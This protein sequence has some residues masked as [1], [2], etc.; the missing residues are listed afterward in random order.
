MIENKRTYIGN[1]HVSSLDNEDLPL[2]NTHTNS[3]VNMRMTNNIFEVQ[4]DNIKEARRIFVA[5]VKKLQTKI[6]FQVGIGRKAGDNA[7][8]YINRITEKKGDTLCRVFN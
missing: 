8:Y 5:M 1:V 7:M 3:F 6:R 4:A 2:W